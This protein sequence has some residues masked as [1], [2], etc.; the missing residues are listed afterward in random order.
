MNTKTQGNV[1]FVVYFDFEAQHFVGVCLTFNIVIEGDDREELEKL[2]RQMAQDHIEVVRE[3]NLSDELLNRPAPQEYWD[4]KDETMEA[5]GSPESNNGGTAPLRQE[6]TSI[7]ST[8]F[9]RESFGDHKR[10]LA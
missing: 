4:I 10:Q 3:Q 5:Q 6:I 7:A 9:S 8:Y 2:L 1:Q